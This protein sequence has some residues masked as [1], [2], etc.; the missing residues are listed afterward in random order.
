MALLKGYLQ[1]SLN[2]V[3]MGMPV[4]GNARRESLRIS[5]CPHDQYL[6]AQWRT[7][8]RTKSRLGQTSAFM[9]PLSAEAKIDITSGK[10]VF[11]AAA[12]RSKMENFHPVKGA[13]PDR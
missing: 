2:A 7:K 3:L 5:Q 4:T 11:S 1:D 6:H 9:P 10:F 13:T 8:A 12:L